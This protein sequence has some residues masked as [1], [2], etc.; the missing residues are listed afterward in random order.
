MI[1]RLVIA[2]ILLAL[3]AGGL[4]GFNLYRSK[5]I[6]QF[7]ATRPIPAVT[8]STVEAQPAPW[9]PAIEAIG[10]VNASQGVDLTVEAAGVVKEILFKSNQHVAAGDMLLRL[11]NVVQHADLEAARTALELDLTNLKRARELQSRGVAT[12]VSLDSSEAAARASEAQVARAT[13]LLDQRQL[14]APFQGTI[15]LSRVELGQ[16]VAPGMIVTTLQDL[17]TMRVDFSLPEQ[18]LPLLKIGLPLQVHIEGDDRAF[19]GEIVGIDPRVD[20]DSRMVSLRGTIHGVNGGLTPGQFVRIRVELP[21]EEGVI[22][23]PQ[24][25][26]VSSLYGDYV[27]VVRPKAAEEAGATAPATAPAAGAAPEAAAQ[28]QLAVQQV[29]V[30]VGRRSAGL[31]EIVKGIA[32]GDLVVTAGQNRLSNGTPAV[33]DNSVNPAVSGSDAASQPAATQPGTPPAGDEGTASK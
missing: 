21:K 11:D 32:S 29:F 20:P 26:L 28:P 9:Q 4:V 18:E 13:A 12:N 33:I 22:A 5:M 31:V 16:Y 10:T 8:V 23:L 17:D 15:G 3:V 2:V 7:F 30:Q 1:K 25:V 19:R 24:T 6:T 27:Y 14:S